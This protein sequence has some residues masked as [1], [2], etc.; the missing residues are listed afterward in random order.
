MDNDIALPGYSSDKYDPTYIA[1]MFDQENI[2]AMKKL[3]YYRNFVT[4]IDECTLFDSLRR[5]DF[6]GVGMY[7]I[8]K[9][10]MDEK[11]DGFVE[12]KSQESVEKHMDVRTTCLKSRTHCYL[13]HDDDLGLLL[14][15]VSDLLDE[16]KDKCLRKIKKISKR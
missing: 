15:T 14:D 2:E 3:R 13:S 9:F 16:H 11:T 10:F 6:T 7:L 12:T 1:G 4:G 5:G 8:D